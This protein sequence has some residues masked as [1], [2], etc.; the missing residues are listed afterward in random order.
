VA[1]F[2]KELYGVAEIHLK[3]KEAKTK[4]K[5]ESD[6]AEHFHHMLHAKHLEGG[7]MDR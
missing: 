6:V 4:F 1:E 2:L 3:C 7:M 5:D